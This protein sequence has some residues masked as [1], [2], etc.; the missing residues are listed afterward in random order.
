[1][2]VLII[3]SSIL[4]T[5]E[6]PL[7]DPDGMKVV[8][9]EKINFVISIIFLIEVLLKIMAFGFLFNGPDSYLRDG[10]NIIDFSI[11][12]V[13]IAATFMKVIRLIKVLR[14]LRMV[15]RYQGLQISIKAL[16]R[17]IPNIFNVMLIATIFIFIFGIICISQFKGTFYDCKMNTLGGIGDDPIILEMDLEINDKFDCI[18]HGGQWIKADNNFDDI[19]ESILT[20]FQMTMVGWVVQAQ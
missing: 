18:N 15:S 9:L 1:M 5:M 17:S 3:V 20:L 19:F 4:L 11:A 7:D 6:S 14:P 13:S 16:I 8:V 12:V 2:I 10:W